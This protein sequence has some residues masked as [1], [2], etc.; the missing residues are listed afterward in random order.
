MV[1]STQE[2]EILKNSFQCLIKLRAIN[3][4][5]FL[6]IRLNISLFSEIAFEL[7]NWVNL[8]LICSTFWVFRGKY[9]PYTPLIKADFIMQA[10]YYNFV[11]YYN[12][13]A[14]IFRPHYVHDCTRYIFFLPYFFIVLLCNRSNIL[15]WYID[16]YTLSSFILYLY[17]E[18]PFLSKNK[19]RL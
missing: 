17:R 16:L 6:F 13:I 18:I 14:C 7:F 8:W 5:L 9:P 2:N 4:S 1:Y 12:H 3:V 11:T 10:W 19:P 15:I